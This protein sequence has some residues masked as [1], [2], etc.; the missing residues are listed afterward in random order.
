MIKVI[1]TLAILSLSS[2]VYA[3]YLGVGIHPENNRISASKTLYLIG[4]YKLNSLRMDYKWSQV[5]LRKGVFN[6]PS[7]ISDDVIEKA[8][9]KKITPIIILDYGNKIYNISKP[10]SDNDILLFTNYAV[11]VAQHFKNKNVIFEIWNEWDQ[12]KPRSYSQS[13]ISAKQYAKLIKA[14]YTAIKPI[15][16]RSIVIAGSFNPTKSEEIKFGKYLIN[17]G[18][19][20]YVDGISIHTYN[21]NQNRI[22]SY[23]ENINR[24]D[25]FY[26][27][28]ESKG[29]TKP[30]YITEFGVSIY[31]NSTITDKEVIDYA[32]SYVSLSKEKD[33][34][35]GVWWYDL[36]NDGDDKMNGENNFGILNSNLEEKN[37]ANFLK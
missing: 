36:I 30:I 6:P 8:I 5:E 1:F 31:G 7:E 24:I 16:P 35:R 10:V 20:N 25:E 34:I 21:F 29:E 27:W 19:L 14:V 32:K 26:K 37:I 23:Q 11:W 9:E 4:K 12:S 15:N 3:F 18:V 17:K 33:Y 22:L 2:N 13:E 28:M